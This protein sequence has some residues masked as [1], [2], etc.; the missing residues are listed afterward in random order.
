MDKHSFYNSQA[1]IKEVFLQFLWNGIRVLKLQKL[2]RLST[3]ISPIWGYKYP[4][5]ATCGHIIQEN[6]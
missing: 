5:L 3:K 4:N 6:F 2:K 1:M